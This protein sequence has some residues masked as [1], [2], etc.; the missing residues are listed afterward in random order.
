MPKKTQWSSYQTLIIL[1]NK[2]MKH[3]GLIVWYLT[4]LNPIIMKYLSSQNS[5]WHKNS[6]FAA[7]VGPEVPL[8]PLGILRIWLIAHL[9]KIMICLVVAYSC[10]II[11]SNLKDSL[12]R[13]ILL[14]FILIVLVLFNYNIITTQWLKIM[15]KDHVN[16]LQL[17]SCIR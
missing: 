6:L 5:S 15:F 16:C 17:I 14:I 13:V 3:L 1:W 9:N 7:T 4:L 11:R 10:Y 8:K 12:R 2:K